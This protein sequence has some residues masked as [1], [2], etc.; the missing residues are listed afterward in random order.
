MAS[1]VIGVVG[2][3]NNGK[4][5]LATRLLTEF[6]GRGLRVSTIKH[7]HHSVDLDRPGKDSHQHRMAGAH[8]TVIASA[9]RF[10]ILH[11]Y[12]DAPE[13]ELDA[14]LTRLATVDLVIVEGFKAHPHPKIEAH[15]SKSQTPLL[16]PHDPLIWGVVSDVELPDLRQPRFG[17]DAIGELCDFIAKRLELPS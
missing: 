12:R 1:P 15:F 10:A 2:Y 3:K 11:E 16:A 17:P 6:T 8:E 14:L 7:T 9:K 4:T 5:R 13:L